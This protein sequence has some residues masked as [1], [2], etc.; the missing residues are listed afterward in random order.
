[1]KAAALQMTSSPDVA[2]NLEQA[3]V[4]LKQARDQGAALA[5]LPENFA[6]MGLNRKQD[7]LAIAEADGS[8]P[9]QDFLSRD[10]AGAFA[11]DRRR[12]RCRCASRARIARSTRI[13]SI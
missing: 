3:G 7:K 12:H 2:A 9:I 5:V 4:L 1:M 13:I 8:G 6:F 10:G 11:V